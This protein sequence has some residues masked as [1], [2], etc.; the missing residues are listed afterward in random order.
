M[1]D[2]NG[3][4]LFLNECNNSRFVK[5]GIHSFIAV[6]QHDSSSILALWGKNHQEISNCMPLPLLTA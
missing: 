1:N 6:C 2:I 4:I 5:L 3:L